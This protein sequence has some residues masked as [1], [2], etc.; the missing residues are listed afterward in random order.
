MAHPMKLLP[1]LTRSFALTLASVAPAQPAAVPPDTTEIRLWPGVA[2]GSEPEKLP[3]PDFAETWTGEPPRR[4]VRFATVPALYGFLPP[5]GQGNGAALILAPGGG[6]STVV[7]EHEGWPVARRLAADGLAVFVLKYRH[8]DRDLALHDARRAIRT[9]RT[10]AAAWGL[11]P[12]RIGL[13]GFSAGGH[14][15]LNTAANPAA[16]EP[17]VGDAVDRADS[18]PDFLLLVYPSPVSSLPA[19]A[20][21][22]A[23]VPASFIVGGI[24]DH[25]GERVLDLSAALLRARVRHE[26]HLFATGPHGFALAPDTPGTREWPGLFAPWLRAQFAPGGGMTDKLLPPA[27]PWGA[28]RKSAP[29]PRPEKQ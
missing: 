22:D 14:L 20:V 26:V 1:F 12:R 13:G 29:P 19:G 28:A 8:W 6:Y 21:V 16:G 7:I 11:D 27:T 10:R 17:R 18:H 23:R 15:A 9:V 25:A 3:R 2:P 5:A 24:A 4:A